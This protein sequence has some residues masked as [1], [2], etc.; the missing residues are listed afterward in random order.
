M[1]GGT[2]TNTTIK[3]M[4][5]SG[6]ELDIFT[7]FNIFKKKIMTDKPDLVWHHNILQIRKVSK[8][9]KELNVPVIATINNLVSDVNGFHIIPDNNFGKPYL[10]CRFF[11]SWFIA[12]KQTRI[13]SPMHKLA[14]ILFYPFRYH[15]RNQRIK[16]L[17]DIAGVIAI[18]PTLARLLKLNGVK[19][20]IHVSPQPI[21]DDF[22]DKT[23]PIK[24]DKKTILYIGGGEPFKGI[25]VLIK[26]FNKLD[27]KNK[28]LLIAGEFRKDHKINF[29]K[30]P[31][32]IKF[33]GVIPKK[34]LKQLYYSVD[35]LAFPSL[36]FEAFGRGWAEALACG[37]PVLTLKDRGGA[38]DY[39]EHKKTGYLVDS[40]I[41]SFTNGMKE[42]LTNNK[43]RN[44]LSKNGLKYAKDNL[45]ASVFVKRINRIFK[46]ILN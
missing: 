7:S 5:E 11:K 1:G 16:V 28:Q 15:R 34:E 2:S 8:L 27:I 10:K 6:H 21:D 43:L 36:W 17:N 4:R 19:R 3:F 22:L 9:C 30:Y 14:S 32:N 45:L 39:L 31:N 18:S 46:E 37:C 40:E 44:T 38:A 20:K 13:H 41:D 42:L 23:K 25:H 29:N 33:L 26:A 24:F 12:F 35:F